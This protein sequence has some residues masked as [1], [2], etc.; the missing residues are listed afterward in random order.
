M[1]H[2]HAL[3][4]ASIVTGLL[5]GM[6]FLHVD[7]TPIPTNPATVVIGLVAVALHIISAGAVARL[8]MRARKRRQ[9]QP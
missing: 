7:V 8:V 6:V 4:L 9:G 2:T 5:A 3:V 1:R